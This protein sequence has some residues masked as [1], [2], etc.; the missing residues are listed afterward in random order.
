MDS[1]LTG[2][3]ALV[4]GGASGIGLATVRALVMEGCTVVVA[5]RHPGSAPTEFPGVVAHVPCDLARR[6]DAIRIVEYVVAEFGRID[7][8]VTSAGVYETAGVHDITDDEWDLTLAVNLTATFVTARAAIEEMARTG[9]GRIVTLSSM[10]AVSGGG[11]AGPAY[12]ATKSAIVGL[13]KSLAKYAGPF[14]IT[15]NTLLPGFIESPMTEQFSESDH[16][17]IRDMTPVRRNGSPEDVAAAVIA[18]ASSRMG[19]VTGAQL[20]VNGGLGIS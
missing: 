18:L 14:G 16:Q 19:F 2:R 13:T 9:W 11:S 6:E 12:V 10:A 4:T 8:L 20:Q 7:I 1:E 3:I 5:D 17:A 15:V